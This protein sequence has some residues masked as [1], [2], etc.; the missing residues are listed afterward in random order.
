MALLWGV[1]PPRT[2]NGIR[3]DGFF[4]YASAGNGKTYEIWP[5]GDP[6][7]STVEW[8]LTLGDPGRSDE[9]DGED[10]D[11]ND[12]DDTENLGQFDDFEKAQ[13]EAELHDI[14]HPPPPDTTTTAEISR[15]HEGTY[16]MRSVGVNGASSK[17]SRCAARAGRGVELALD[18]TVAGRLATG[19]PL[20]RLTDV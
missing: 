18:H 19:S 1:L 10:A 8:E 11:E 14:A 13:L 9:N 16:G 12:I 2:V 20:V 5:V 17:Y 15:P 6:A 3:K 7:D 4:A